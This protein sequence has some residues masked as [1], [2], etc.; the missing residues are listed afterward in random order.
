VIR[1]GVQAQ[2]ID[3][4]SKAYAYDMKRKNFK[5]AATNATV[6]VNNL[7]KYFPD[8]KDHLVGRLQQARRRW[9]D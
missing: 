9:K 2:R 3:A 6:I 8:S 1:Q 7:A 4:L 5:D